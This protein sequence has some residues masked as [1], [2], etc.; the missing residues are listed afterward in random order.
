MSDFA[1][2]YT[3]LPDSEKAGHALGLQ[4]REAM[5]PR[6]DAIIVFATSLYDHATLLRALRKACDPEMLVGCSSA[7]KFTTDAHGGGL[8]SALAISS[9]EMEFSAGIGR[10]VSCDRRAA[11]EQVVS[12]FRGLKNQDYHYRTALV[13]I[14]A[15]SGL[16]EAFIEDLALRTKGAYQFFGG[17]AGDNAQFQYTPVFY[18]EEVVSDGVVAL[19]ILS[20]KPLGIGVRHGWQPMGEEMHVTASSG[21]LLLSLDDR[22]AVE[23][24]K[25]YASETGQKFNPETP[26]PFFLHNLI[27][28]DTGTGYKLRV[29]L[30]VNADGSILCVADIPRNARVKIM[31]SNTISTTEAARA[32]TIAALQ[33]LCGAKPGIA[34]FFD[35]VATRLRMGYEF[36]QELGA[37]QD[38]LG[39]AR[40]VCCNSHGQIARAQGQFSGFHNCT[41]VVCVFP[42]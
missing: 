14:D 9:R 36:G 31:G 38:T 25:A 1:V 30:H 22:P 24:F 7:G 13:L 32:A 29:P 34:L 16:S 27:G 40:Y 18:N 19:E 33:K 17:G 8:A 41:A 10:D 35:C 15:R 42:E 23:A 5:L 21:T 3:D 12:S 28:V 2:V 11:A 20:D 6:P 37:V 26:M 39:S 4:I